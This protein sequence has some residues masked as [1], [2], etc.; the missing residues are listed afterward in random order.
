M[1]GPQR[2]RADAA[3]L[4]DQVKDL[5]DHVVLASRPVSMEEIRSRLTAIGIGVDWRAD[6]TRRRPR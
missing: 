3:W 2:N 5:A 4:R 6:A 1:T